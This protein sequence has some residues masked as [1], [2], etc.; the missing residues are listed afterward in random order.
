MPESSLLCSCNKL[1]PTFLDAI[2]IYFLGPQKKSLYRPDP[3]VEEYLKEL[4]E[5]AKECGYEKDEKGDWVLFPKREKA[6]Q[7]LGTQYEIIKEHG[8]GDVTI[9]MAEHGLAVITT[10]GDIFTKTG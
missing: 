8:D 6:L 1:S 10:E 7:S 4:G 9:K 5:L 3:D 2:E